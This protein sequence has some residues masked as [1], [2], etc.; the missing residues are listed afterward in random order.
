[1]KKIIAFTSALVLCMGFSG[2]GNS[3]NDSGSPAE[4]TAAETT[5]TTTTTAETTTTTT[6]TT[7]AATTTAAETTAETNSDTADILAE[8][9]SSGAKAPEGVREYRIAGFGHIFGKYSLDLVEGDSYDSYYK[10]NVEDFALGKALGEF[11][12]RYNIKTDASSGTLGEYELID[13]EGNSLGQLTEKELREKYDPAAGYEI[14]SFSYDGAVKLS[15]LEEGKVYEAPSKNDSI[16][17]VNDTDTDY[18]V[19]VSD[20]FEY[21]ENSY[22]YPANSSGSQQD[23]HVYDDVRVRIE[24]QSG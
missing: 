5:T 16:S 13:P 18:T 6:T 3:G 22:S 10:L 15:E 23:I 12:S 8:L 2:C 1:M 4:T 14:V 9:E 24:K 11:S 20:T 17:F 7:T 19:W 21:I